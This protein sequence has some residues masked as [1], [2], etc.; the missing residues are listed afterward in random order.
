LGYFRNWNSIFEDRLSELEALTFSFYVFVLIV[1][2][3][4]QNEGSDV[5]AQDK[6]RNLDF[7]IKAFYFPPSSLKVFH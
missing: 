5:L 6:K 3:I 7:F 4:S 1:F 2:S